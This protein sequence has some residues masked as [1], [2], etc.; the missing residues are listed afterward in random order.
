MLPRRTPDDDDRWYL[1]AKKECCINFLRGATRKPVIPVVFKPVEEKTPVRAS[2]E[3]PVEYDA[4]ARARRPDSLV[5][6]CRSACYSA[7][8][9]VFSLESGWLA[10]LSAAIVICMSFHSLFASGGN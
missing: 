7:E 8:D 3:V 9:V 10:L 5:R 1:W 2:P 4:I 6:Y